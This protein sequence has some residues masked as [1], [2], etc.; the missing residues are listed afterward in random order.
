MQ[1]RILSESIREALKLK[2]KKKVDIS[3]AL[4]VS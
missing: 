2:R 4:F 1:L 3:N